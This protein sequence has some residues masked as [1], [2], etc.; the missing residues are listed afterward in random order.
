VLVYEEK[1]NEFRVSIGLS[2]SEDYL[3]IGSHQT[4]T[5]EWR[6]VDADSPESS[7]RLLLA[8]ESD[9]EYGVDHWGDRFY[10]RTNWQACDFRL[11]SATLAEMGDKARWREEIATR[12]DVLL[13][14]FE[15]FA[16]HLVVGER[17]EG[18]RRIRVFPWGKWGRAELAESHEI[19]FEEEIFTA[20]LMA[21]AEPDTTTLR[22]GYTSMTTPLTTIDYDMSSRRREV[23][24]VEQVVGDFLPERYVTKR[25]IASVRDKETVYIS[26]VHRAD[27]DLGRPHPTLLYGYGS[28][29][30]SMDPQ[31]SSARLSLLDRGFIFAIA[32]IRGGQEKGRRWYEDGKLLNK[33]HTFEDFIDVARYL[34]SEGITQPELLTAQGGSAGG[35]LIGAVANM[36]P[37]LFR[38]IVAQVP[39]VDVLTTMLDESIPLTTFEYDEWGN[40]QERAYYDYIESYSPYD[41][42]TAQDYPEMLVLTGL[43]DSQVQYWEPAKWVARLRHRGTGDRRLIFKTDLE[44]G[45]G[46]AS[47][48]F[49]RHE[50]TALVYAF[51]LEA[52]GAR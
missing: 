46:G 20:G 21:N 1:D 11:M 31:F 33:K 51:L 10:I 9:H 40:P 45:H 16:G 32:H 27:L 13:R 26:L 28:Y 41:Q 14:N 30:L 52:V 44:A 43:H 5:N 4:T 15:L 23:R 2:R 48:R 36:E 17:R 19:T 8:R 6:V 29:G 42:V 47:G 50:D 25:Q 35:L 22:L 34:V 18:I 12:P 49:R 3:L 24:K 39:F 37:E 7:S 38:A